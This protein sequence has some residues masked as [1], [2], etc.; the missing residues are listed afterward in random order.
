[1]KEEEEEKGQPPPVR[2]D[3]S[4]TRVSSPHC[5]L[6]AKPGPIRSQ[7]LMPCCLLS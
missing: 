4:R 5:Q 1:M 3:G 7:I 2:R 6:L